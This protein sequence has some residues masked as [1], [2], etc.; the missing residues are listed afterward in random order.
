MGTM[1]FEYLRTGNNLEKACLHLAPN[2]SVVEDLASS[3]YKHHRFA[4]VGS[5][6]GKHELKVY[7]T[8]SI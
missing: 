4:V 8:E 3:A 6:C 5:V 1:V 2:D 7:R